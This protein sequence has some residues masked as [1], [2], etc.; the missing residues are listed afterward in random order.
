M[1]KGKFYTAHFNFNNKTEFFRENDGYLGEFKDSNNNTI[2]IGV[3]YCNNVWS[4]TEL[5]TGCLV[6]GAM[7]KKKEV[8]SKLTVELMNKITEKLNTEDM[9]YRIKKMN[10]YKESLSC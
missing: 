9:R 8:M 10:E 5:S 6:V 7:K 2:K 4:A 1:K 3:N